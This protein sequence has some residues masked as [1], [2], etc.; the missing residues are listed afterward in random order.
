MRRSISLIVWTVFICTTLALAVGCAPSG[1]RVHSEEHE[2]VVTEVVLSRSKVHPGESF[3]VEVTVHNNSGSALEL[4]F[5]NQQQFGVRIEL[6]GDVV[7][8]WPYMTSPA[9]SRLFIGVGESVSKSFHL[10]F[11]ASGNP[12]NFKGYAA[13]GLLLQGEYQ[14]KGGLLGHRDG[15]KWGSA[16]LVVA[17]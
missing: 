3:E 2:G 1:A 16:E 17:R 7:A 5:P 15:F 11:K 9:L 4:G 8:W 12:G 14:V 6:Q 10:G 13:S